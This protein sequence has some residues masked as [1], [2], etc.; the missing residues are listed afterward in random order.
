MYGYRGVKLY[1]FVQGVH[2]QVSPK[3]TCFFTY[4]MPT[5]V[6]YLYKYQGHEQSRVNHP[7]IA[8]GGKN[9]DGSWKTSQAKVYPPSL[10][11]AIA[12]A[13]DDNMI[14]AG[15]TDGD[16]EIILGGLTSAQYEEHFARFKVEFDP[17]DEA[18]IQQQV[19][20]ADC[21]IYN[22]YFCCWVCVVS[23]SLIS[24]WLE[25]IV[26]ARENESNY[27]KM[28]QLLKSAPAIF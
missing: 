26:H 21:M 20:K 16:K 19:M 4:M 17:Y 14:G 25:S 5:L 3:P 23:V 22:S 28:L 27:C 1:V 12:L 6:K 13:A 18:D 9:S 7:K 2:D 11:I 8:L 10:C 24:F 15:I